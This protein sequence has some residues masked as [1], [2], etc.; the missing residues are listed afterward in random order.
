[1]SCAATLFRNLGQC[2]ERADLDHVSPNNWLND[3]LWLGLAYH[4]WRAPLLVN[5]NYWLLFAPDPSDPA[6]PTHSPP[7]LPA[8][9]VALPDPNPPKEAA[10]G[11]QG[12]GQEWLDANPKPGRGLT[13]DEAVSREEVS[14][15]QIKKAAW[16]VRRYAE[17]REMVQK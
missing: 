6:P 1:M 11:G 2:T 13:W 5:S 10:E 3:T 7:A 14:D 12:G 4:T 17:F 9:A 16:M 8:K 15:W